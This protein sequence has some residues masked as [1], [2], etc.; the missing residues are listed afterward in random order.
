MF[1]I[2]TRTAKTALSNN[3]G[4]NNGDCAGMVSK[5]CDI[6]WEVYKASCMV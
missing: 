3:E 1:H 6:N 5:F 4:A 2:F